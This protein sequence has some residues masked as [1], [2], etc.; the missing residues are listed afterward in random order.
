[1]TV[2][3]SDSRFPGAAGLGTGTAKA[4]KLLA[5][6]DTVES[7]FVSVRLVYGQAHLTIDE[8]TPLSDTFRMFGPQGA[9]LADKYGVMDKRVDFVGL[10]ATYDP[11]KWFVTGEWAD[12]NTRSVLGKKIAWYA[13]GGYRFGKVTPYVTYA[14]IKADS[15]TSDPG[16]GLAGLPPPVAALGAQLN[17]LLNQQ[18]AAIPQQ[19]TASIGVRWDFLG[20]ATLKLQYDRVSLEA[21]SHGTFGN[22][23]PGFPVG[24]RVHLFS[25]AVDFVF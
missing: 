1:V 3:R 18:L 24:G 21:S 12:F 23:Q 13:S 4:R 8:Y 11:G 5:A 2:G 20:N 17:T 6:V 15:N 14:R 7:G 19:A 10:G 25:A 22:L 16:L 9:A